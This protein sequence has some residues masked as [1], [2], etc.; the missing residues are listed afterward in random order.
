MICK[1]TGNECPYYDLDVED[2]KLY[3]DC[4]EEEKG[5]TNMS[6]IVRA[7]HDEFGP[8]WEFNLDDFIVF[9]E[10]VV[11]N[12]TRAEELFEILAGKLSDKYGESEDDGYFGRWDR[13]DKGESMGIA[14][15]CHDGTELCLVLFEK[16]PWDARMQEEYE[17]EHTA[18]EAVSMILETV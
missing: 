16:E 13:R 14:W 3:V 18:E 15:N 9:G 6:Y 10:T 12:Q 5:G 11:D 2:C 17:P 8:G 4:P 7:F 1:K